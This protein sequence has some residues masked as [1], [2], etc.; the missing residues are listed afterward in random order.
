[1]NGPARPIRI[2]PSDRRVAGDSSKSPSGTMTPVPSLRVMPGDAN[3]NR[4]SAAAGRD[5]DHIGTR[6][7]N[8]RGRGLDQRQFG[9][10]GLGTIPRGRA[11]APTADRGETAMSGHVGQHA[12]THDAKPDERDLRGRSEHFRRGPNRARAGR[13]WPPVHIWVT[14]KRTVKPSV[15]FHNYCRQV[16]PDEGQIASMTM[17]G[18]TE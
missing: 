3:A 6:I 4:R 11:R 9:K 16:R 10:D 5:I 15:A 1:M 17:E 12:V 2:R 7:G 14:S 8:D 13:R 18:R